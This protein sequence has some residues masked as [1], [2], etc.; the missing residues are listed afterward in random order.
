MT[1]KKHKNLKEKK[2]ACLIDD[3]KNIRESM[4][5]KIF[6]RKDGILQC[7]TAFAQ[8]YGIH[9]QKDNYR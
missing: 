8:G 4:N 7:P 9:G 6:R 2:V 1:K 3:V 5:K